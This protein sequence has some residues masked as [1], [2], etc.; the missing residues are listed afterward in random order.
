VLAEKI[1]TVRRGIN[2]RKQVQL[3][4]KLRSS[5]ITDKV[6]PGNIQS[7]RRKYGSIAE[8]VGDDSV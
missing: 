4:V 5:T 7:S 3:T 2:S 8:S 1:N 6:F